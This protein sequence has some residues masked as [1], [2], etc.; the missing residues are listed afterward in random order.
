VSRSDPWGTLGLRLTRGK[1]AL[2]RSEFADIVASQL[3]EFQGS[4]KIIFIRVCPRSTIGKVSAIVRCSPSG[5][6]IGSD[7]RIPPMH[8]QKQKCRVFA[9]VW[10]GERTKRGRAVTLIFSWR[11]SLFQRQV[12]WPLK[13]GLTLTRSERC[14]SFHGKTLAAIIESLPNYDRC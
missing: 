13:R 8:G 4:K 10:A 2:G 3:S 12:T 1:T 7:S 11:S 9:K 6:G 14:R 5:G